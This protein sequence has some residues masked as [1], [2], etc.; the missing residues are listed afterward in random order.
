[1]F[2]YYSILIC[3]IFVC[4][5]SEVTSINGE[6]VTSVRNKR[7]FN[8]LGKAAIKLSRLMRLNQATRILITHAEEIER[9]T[10]LKGARIIYL[11]KPGGM[12][13]AKTDFQRIVGTD[14]KVRYSY[15]DDWEMY[16]SRLG[17]NFVE[18]LKSDVNNSPSRIKMYSKEGGWYIVTYE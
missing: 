7:S 10:D 16:T 1:M 12:E 6:N 8:R 13:K 18:F 5:L 15:G 9:T 14:Y 4:V 3:A 2:T 11:S 17:D